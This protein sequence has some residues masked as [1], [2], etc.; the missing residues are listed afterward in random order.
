MKTAASLRLV[1]TLE[2][3]VLSLYA[4]DAGC[5]CCCVTG[6][7]FGDQ[8][9][10]D[11]PITASGEEARALLQALLAELSGH[12]VAQTRTVRRAQHPT[13]LVREVRDRLRAWGENAWSLWLYS[14]DSEDHLRNQARNL[15][16]LAQ[17]LDL[18]IA[19]IQKVTP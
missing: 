16:A 19:E 15:L 8:A 17:Q 1:A 12:L 2:D 14:P 4:S 5:G 18:A 13:D 10:T 11:E 3:G 6:P 7:V 9:S